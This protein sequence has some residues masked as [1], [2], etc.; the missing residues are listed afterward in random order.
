[1]LYTLGTRD[2]ASGRISQAITRFTEAKSLASH[3]RAIATECDLWL[4]DCYYRQG[5]YGRAA[6]AYNSYLSASRA[7]DANRPL[8][9]YDLGY[10]RFAEK[11]YGDAR[12]DFERVV[13]NPGNLDK[14]VI[15]DAYNRLGDCHYYQTDFSSASANYDRAYSLNPEAGDY[16]VFQKAMMKGLGKD[17]HGKI[18]SLDDMMERYP[19]SGLLPAALLEKAESYVALNRPGDAVVIYESLVKRCASSYI[20]RLQY[21]SGC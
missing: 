7:D 5:E 16:A 21:P 10:A 20:D 1:M 2:L 13:N 15:A 14:T 17:H 19:T 4:G 6:R 11:R 18:E 3:S 8:A 12:T 9:Y